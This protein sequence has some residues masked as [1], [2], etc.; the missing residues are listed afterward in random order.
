MKVNLKFTEYREHF[1]NVW[2]RHLSG[3]YRPRAL[4][5]SAGVWL[6]Y[7][8]FRTGRSP[9]TSPTPPQSPRSS[10]YQL[11]WPTGESHNTQHQTG[12]INMKVPGLARVWTLWG[13]AEQG[14]G[15]GALLLP[16]VPLEPHPPRDGD[17]GLCPRRPRTAPSGLGQGN[18]LRILITRSS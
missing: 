5:R 6:K 15:P 9:D 2:P 1:N 3:H 13:T 4:C 8:I 7:F 10:G 14:A 11:L 16:L 12:H 17:V 18:G